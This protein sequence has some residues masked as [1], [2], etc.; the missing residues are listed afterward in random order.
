MPWLPK[1]DKE[2][3]VG[4]AAVELFAERETREELVGFTMEDG[5]VPPEGAQVVID[6]YPAGRVTSARRS[7]EVGAII[8]LAWLPPERSEDGTRFEIRVDRQLCGARVSRGAFFDPAGA[9][10]R[11]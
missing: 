10:M 6:G 4:K 5:V 3:F 2:D 7:E 8:G 1:L 11:S 9:R